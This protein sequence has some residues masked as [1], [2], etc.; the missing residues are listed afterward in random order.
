MKK[1]KLIMIPLAVLCMSSLFSC[2][3]NGDISSKNDI[4]ES[5]ENTSESSSGSKAESSSGSKSESTSESTSSSTSESSSQSSSSSTPSET[6]THEYAT[7]WSSDATKHWH[8][9]TCGHNTKSEEAEHTYNDGEETADGTKF[10]CTVCGYTKTEASKY[11]VI[12]AKWNDNFNSITN[13]TIHSI[14]TI[15][16]FNYYVENGMKYEVVNGTSG[17]Y[18]KENDKYYA[19]STSS[20]NSE[21]TKTEISK[22]D[23]EYW[24]TKMLAFFANNYSQFTYDLETKSYKAQ[25]LDL[26]GTIL[27][28]IKVTF[29][30]DKITSCNYKMGSGDSTFD[31][32]CYDFGSTTTITVP[33]D[34]HEHTYATTW[35]M[36]E[37]KHWHAATCGHDI[38]KKDEAEH[39]MVDGKCSVCGYQEGTDGIE[40]VLSSDESHYIAGVSEDAELS[41]DF[42]IA[43]FYNGKPVTEIAEA[44]FLY[45]YDIK[46]ISIPNTIT[47]IGAYAFAACD[48][49][50]S[51]V[52]PNSVTSI[53]ASAFESCSS[54]KSITLSNQITRIEEKMLGRCE[55]LTS[56]IIPNGVKTIGSGAFLSCSNLENVQI[57]NTVTKIGEGAFAKCEKLTDL[58]IPDSVIRIEDDV[59]T[60]CETLKNL[61]LSNNLTYLGLNALEGCD[62]LIY[63]EY[64]NGRYLGSSNNSFYLLAKY[65]PT[66]DSSYNINE[67]CKMIYQKVFSSYSSLTSIVIPDSVI[68]IGYGAFKDCEN[69]ETV[70]LSKNLLFLDADVFEACNSLN[71]NEYENGYYLGNNENQYQVL[72]KTKSNDMTT[73]TINENCRFIYSG[74]FEDCS[75]IVSIN[76]PNSVVCIGDYAF[77]WCSALTSIVL[78]SN[79]TSIGNYAFNECQSLTNIVIPSTV[80]FIGEGIIYGCSQLTNVYYEGT[81]L[82]WN[83]ITML[84]NE[85]LGEVNKLYYSET[86][87]SDETNKYWHYVDGVIT[88]W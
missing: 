9:D 30:N 50:T 28:D 47:T 25:S 14:G 17:I 73:F 58:V 56:I 18:I 77:S 84:Y 10:T 22:S 57:A 12:E 34:A 71:L 52:I 37:T 81:V 83:D 51:V 62:Q 43:S 69:L 26:N 86:N 49:L 7:A 39:T 23:Y 65:I 42:V 68:S 76:I 31:V 15:E 78:S 53:G 6:H 64:E 82:Q 59:F 33:T 44:A 87:P 32:S 24:Q 63:N 36:D 88:T 67:T 61:T 4:S 74:A 48:G 21:W 3:D 55:N 60:D 29:E 75:N 41:G 40:Y 54:L 38:F 13:C 70:T 20:A 1:K 45:Q 5:G 27:N 2:R 85:K 72:V 80:T 46:S 11:R 8:D 35:S 79:V 66:V 19:Y 16:Q